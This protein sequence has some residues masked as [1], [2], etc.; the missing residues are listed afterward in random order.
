VAEQTPSG[1]TIGQALSEKI[2]QPVIVDN[3]PGINGG[4]AVDI[5]MNSPADGYNLILVFTSLMAINPAVY[6]KLSYNP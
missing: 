5:S 3:R 2:G 4:L 6:E 1:R